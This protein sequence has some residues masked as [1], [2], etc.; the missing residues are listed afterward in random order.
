MSGEALC[1]TAVTQRLMIRPVLGIDGSIIL[2]ELTEAQSRDSDELTGE[3]ES[4][5]GLS[6]RPIVVIRYLRADLDVTRPPSS[7]IS[8]SSSSSSTSTRDCT[9]MLP[10]LQTHER[11]EQ[12]TTA[13]T[14]DSLYKL[15]QDDSEIDRS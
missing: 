2:S 5:S 1:L 14:S 11:I 13:H 9:L 8:T 12:L 10:G 4:F 15:I 3:A 6:A 7:R